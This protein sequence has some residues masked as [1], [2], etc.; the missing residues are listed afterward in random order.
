M[1][2]FLDDIMLIFMES[3]IEMHAYF[4]E[5]NKLHPHIKFT[6]SHM[7]LDSEKSNPQSCPCS[8][9]ESIP[10]LDTSCGI[11]DGQI[12]TDLYRKPTDKKK[13]LLTSSCHP[14]ECLDLNPFSLSMR[15]ETVPLLTSDMGKKTVS[16][17]AH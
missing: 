14:L 1:K 11:K 3:I 15:R 6:M 13:Y 9:L 17:L 5:I 16:V 12:I 4:Q 10:Y 2:R 7:K 8:S